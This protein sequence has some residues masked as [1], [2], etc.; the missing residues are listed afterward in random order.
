MRSVLSDLGAP[1]GP[2][3]GDS[4]LGGPGVP[5][6][7]EK[8]T[9]TLEGTEAAAG[10]WSGAGSRGQY[11]WKGSLSTPIN[12]EGP[13]GSPLPRTLW[14]DRGP[15][16]LPPSPTLVGCLIESCSQSLLDT[17]WNPSAAQPRHWGPQTEQMCRPCLVGRQALLC[18]KAYE[19]S[20]CP[21][22]GSAKGRRWERLPRHLTGDSK[23]DLEGKSGELKDDK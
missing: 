15:Q 21:G 7:M 17:P 12:P 14:A 23:L 2:G 6:D 5:G 3:A 4:V 19:G 16:H 20:V 11:D 1:G 9:W 8:P 22:C 10:R 13:L 18:D